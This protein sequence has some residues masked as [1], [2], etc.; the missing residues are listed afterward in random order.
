M[1][2]RS[3]QE[4]VE[5]LLQFVFEEF[6]AHALRAKRTSGLPRRRAGVGG[7]DLED[8]P[9]KVIERP[10]HVRVVGQRAGDGG[11][12]GFG[13]R[14]AGTRLFARHA[15]AGACWRPRPGPAPLRLRVISPSLTS[16]RPI[17]VI[18]AA[19]VGDDPRLQVGRR[20]VELQGDEAL[21]RARL[22]VLEHALVAGV[23]GDR[24]AGSPAARRSSS[25]RLSIGSTRRRSVSG[26]ITTVVSLRASTISSR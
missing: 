3:E 19:F 23:V 12:G 4:R 17:A 7:G 25:P 10:G 5:P 8:G 1:R 24:P 2:G 14:P 15:P 20:V 16:F 9:D 11:I 26:W 22:Q 6:P 18:D 21:P 13:R